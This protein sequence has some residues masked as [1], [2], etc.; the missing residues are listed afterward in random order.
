MP[1]SQNAHDM[2]SKLC[3]WNSIITATYW[4]RLQEPLK[5]RKESSQ[6]LLQQELWDGCRG[7]IGQEG[8]DE[9]LNV[10]FE[11]DVDLHIKYHPK[12]HN[13]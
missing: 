11:D 7:D 3:G 8:E 5:I 4:T 2:F 6:K 13:F 12:A 9:E 1:G 10:C